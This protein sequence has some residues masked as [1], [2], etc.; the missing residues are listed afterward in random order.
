[1]DVGKAIRQFLTNWMLTV[2]KRLLMVAVWRGLGRVLFLAPETEVSI[3]A[4]R[5]LYSLRLGRIKIIMYGSVCGKEDC[6]VIQEMECNI[7]MDTKESYLETS[8]IVDGK[9]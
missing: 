8:P 5:K 9:Y 3:K 4:I 7:V 6:K 2:L 1:M